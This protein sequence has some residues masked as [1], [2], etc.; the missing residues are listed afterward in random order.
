MMFSATLD[1]SSSVTQGLHSSQNRGASR[2]GVEKFA[3]DAAALEGKLVAARLMR[4]SQI[5]TGLAPFLAM[6]L[7]AAAADAVV[8]EQMGEFMAKRALNLGG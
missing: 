4:N 1:A 3:G 8:C 7:D 6:G 5:G 2:A